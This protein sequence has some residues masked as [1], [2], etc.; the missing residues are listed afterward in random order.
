[1]R[2][3]LCADAVGGVWTQTCELRAAL[4]E[5]GVEV[6]VATLG[7]QPPPED[8]PY[9]PC[10]LE[11]EDDPWADVEGSARWL[12]E[13]AEE[14]GAEVIQLGSFAH[15]AASWPVPTV[16]VAHSCLLSWQLAVRG[17][18]D[19]RT[20]SIYGARV[21]SG[22]R[23]TDALVAPTRAMLASVNELYGVGGGI[24]INNGI[25][26][27]LAP[28][29][30]R[31]PVVL[32]AGRMWDEAKGL[33]E[34]ALAAA[35]VPWRV[36]V[37][38]EGADAAPAAVRS[39]G[40]L[41][42]VALRRRMAE[43]ALFAHPARYEPFGLA[44]LEAAAAGCALVLGDIASLHE[45]WDGAAEFVA[46]G[47]P[48]DLAAALNALIADEARRARLAERARERAVRYTARRM[49]RA[50]ARLYARLVSRPRVLA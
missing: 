38:G 34:L 50:Y 19:R 46:P 5:E 4:A 43:V 9:L 28:A 8:G 32:A 18:V 27:G 36:E 1:M 15:G 21:S 39:L 24:V 29:R 40:R 37:A 3:L 12:A 16:T 17:A 35:D 44:P 11:W 48:R 30:V 42:R 20:R 45:L 49:A 23:A 31:E 22:L 25:D 6:L 41:A 33:R 7:P 13:L 2:A 26:P 10:R 47:R 14:T